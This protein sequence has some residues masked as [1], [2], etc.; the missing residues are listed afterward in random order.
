MDLF[1]FFTGDIICNYINALSFFLTVDLVIK[2]WYCKGKLFF[3]N[4]NLSQEFLML[5]PTIYA[6]VCSFYHKI[7]LSNDCLCSCSEYF[8]MPCFDQLASNLRVACF[9]YAAN[10]WLFSKLVA[11][12]LQ[13]VSVALKTWPLLD[14]QVFA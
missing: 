8:L 7:D 6:R 12:V 1:I 3:L 14:Q 9:D 11:C 13:Q 5:S 10:I 2:L 4:F